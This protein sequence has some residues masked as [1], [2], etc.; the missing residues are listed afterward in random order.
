LGNEK[1]CPDCGQA[2]KGNKI[3]FKSF[4]FEIFNGFFNFEAKFWNTIIPLLTKPGKVSIDYI[5]GKRQRYANPFR[6][7]LTVSILFF[8]ILGLSKTLDKFRELKNGNVLET[9]PIVSAA[10][11]NKDIDSLEAKIGKQLNKSWLPL[12]T[13]QK[14][15]IINDAVKKAK[16]TTL[17]VNTDALNISLG[18]DTRLD[19]FIAF[20]KKYP[21][22]SVNDALDSLQY[23]KTLLNRFFYNRGKV[24]NLVITKKDAREQFINQILSYGSIALFI[25]LPI[26]TLFLKL[27]YIRGKLTYIDHLVFVFHTQTV[28]FML[29]CIYYLI[30]LF[31]I[32]PQ[33][34]IFTLLFLVYLFLAMR[35]FYNQGIFKTAL[36]FIMLNFVYITISSIGVTIVLLLSF[37]LY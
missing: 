29:L 12:D 9:S 13:L 37:A 17:L 2:N 32:N 3:T 33:L 31:N 35:K 1:F 16:D 4:V 11:K 24:A 10:Q 14:Q 21:E 8:L 15:K 34:W 23:E 27:F 25:F 26:F 18:G 28:F 30:V 7:Y 6:F 22:I 19:K 20:Q 5:N 36:K